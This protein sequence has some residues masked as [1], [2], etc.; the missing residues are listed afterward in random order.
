MVLMVLGNRKFMTS[1][2]PPKSQVGGTNCGA[3]LIPYTSFSYAVA[4]EITQQ[5]TMISFDIILEVLVRIIFKADK[6][7]EYKT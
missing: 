6:R 1:G 7:T 3:G 4:L 5:T 2:T